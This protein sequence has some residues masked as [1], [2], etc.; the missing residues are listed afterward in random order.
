MAVK[1][2][3]FNP[4]WVDMVFEGKNHNYGA[5]ILRKDSSKRHMWALFSACIFFVAAVTGP[6]LIK[7]ILPEKH[8]GE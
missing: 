4:E 2:N 3:I 6:G 7:S 1:I 8:A 5:Y